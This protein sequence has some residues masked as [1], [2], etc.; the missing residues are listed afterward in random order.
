[1]RF[2][3]A[4]NVKG[5]KKVL[6]VICEAETRV[7]N[8]DCVHD[9]QLIPYILLLPDRLCLKHTAQPAQCSWHALVLK[10]IKHTVKNHRTIRDSR[11]K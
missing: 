5:E 3:T 7:T 6:G 9:K 2:H 1:M 4:E 11:G 8:A 10:T